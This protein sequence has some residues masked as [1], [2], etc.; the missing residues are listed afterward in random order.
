MIEIDWCE[1]AKKAIDWSKRRSSCSIYHR[2]N[3]VCCVVSSGLRLFYLSVCIHYHY[4]DRV[5]CKRMFDWCNGWKYYCNNLLDRHCLMSLNNHYSRYKL[6]LLDFSKEISCRSSVCSLSM[7]WFYCKTKELR[8][9]LFQL[10][11]FKKIKRIT[12]CFFLEIEI[13]CFKFGRFVNIEN[14]SCIECYFR[15]YEF[16]FLFSSL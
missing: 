9:Y 7:H 1:C 3:I 16:R 10:L 4:F 15:Q 5:K 13:V 12:N 2:S 8:K 11:F 14:R 6:M